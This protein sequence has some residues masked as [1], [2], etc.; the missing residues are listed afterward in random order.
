MMGITEKTL[1]HTAEAFQKR[2]TEDRL[3]RIRREIT[4][5]TYL[6]PDKIDATVA[7]LQKVLCQ[8]PKKARRVG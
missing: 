1:V 3:T 5:G 4:E 7:A 6:T 2:D 8:Q